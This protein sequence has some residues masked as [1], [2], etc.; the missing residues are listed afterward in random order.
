VR[1]CEASEVMVVSNL[2]D[3]VARLRGYE[4]LAAALL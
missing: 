2:P 3:P 1:A 4:L